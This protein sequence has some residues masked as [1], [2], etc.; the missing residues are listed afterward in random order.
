M[1]TGLGFGRGVARLDF[2]WSDFFVGSL[3]GMFLGLFQSYSW[4]FAL[5]GEPLLVYWSVFVLSLVMGILLFLYFGEL[6]VGVLFAIVLSVLVTS[7]SNMLGLSFSGNLIGLL[8]LSFVFV[9]GLLGV[10]M[11]D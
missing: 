8:A 5:F 9:I 6:G 11:V 10:R 2:D 3:V 7:A 1:V 4:N